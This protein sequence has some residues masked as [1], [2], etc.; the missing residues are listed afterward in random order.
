MRRASPWLMQALRLSACARRA[1]FLPRVR[2][3]RRARRPRRPGVRVAGS[4]AIDVAPLL[5]ANTRVLAALTLPP[6]YGI[7]CAGD[8][9]EDV[10]LARAARAT[11]FRPAP[12]PAARKGLGRAAPGGTRGAPQC[13]GGRSRCAGAAQRRRRRCAATRLRRRALDV[14]EAR[15][16]HVAAARSGRRGVVPHARRSRARGAARCRFRGAGTGPPT[17]THPQ[18]T[19]LGWEAFARIVAGTRLPVYALGGLT[20]DDLDTAIDHGAHGVALRRAAWPVGQVSS[21][22]VSSGCESDSSGA[23]GVAIR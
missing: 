7:S 17:P 3:G 22:P 19:P 8:L 1:P 15:A 10:F 9:G 18:A 21:R 11:R 23:S 14:G 2:V 5:P 4:E 13:A 20:G 16:S 6:V 12:D